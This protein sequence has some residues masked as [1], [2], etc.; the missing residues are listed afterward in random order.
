MSFERLRQTT[1]RIQ[2]LAAPTLADFAHRYGVTVSEL[3]AANRTAHR[4]WTDEAA[5]V[6]EV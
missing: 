1:V 4:A 3:H 5:F 6:R 2:R